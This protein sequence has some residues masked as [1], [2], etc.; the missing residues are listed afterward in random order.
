MLCIFYLKRRRI[1]PLA[2]AILAENGCPTNIWRFILADF[3]V[4]SALVKVALKGGYFMSRTPVTLAERPELE[5]QIPRLHAEG[6]PAFMHA[7]AVAVRYWGDLLSTF[8]EYQYVLCDD[9]DTLVAAG[10]AIPLVWDGTVEGLPEGWDAAIMQGFRDYEQGQAPTAL[11]GLSIVIA[12]TQQGRGLS[13]LM[14]RAMKDLAAA[15]GLSRVIIP[16]RPS[17]KSRYPLVPMQRYIQWRQ[18]DGSPFDPW[19]R[20]HQRLGA[21]VL[22]VAPRSMVITGTVAEWEQW[23]GMRFPESGTYPVAGALEPIIIDC[24]GNSGRYEESNVWV[25][26]S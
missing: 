13:E 2:V 6:W 22:A 23:T 24:E 1:F 21:E 16:V 17:L 18:P 5:A 11:C 25:C 20:I 8:A 7:D 15:D 12:P 26:Y 14:V 19:L 9:A 4:Y 3:L 10:H